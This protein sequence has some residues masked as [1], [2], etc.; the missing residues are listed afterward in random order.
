MGSESLDA[1]IFFD[2]N[3]SRDLVEAYYW[4]QKWFRSRK[5]F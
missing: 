5:S 3:Y 4:E 1:R 2:F